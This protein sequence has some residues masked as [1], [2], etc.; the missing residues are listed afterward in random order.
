MVIIQRAVRRMLARREAKQERMSVKIG[1]PFFLSFFLSSS[2]L[3]CNFSSMLP[4][5]RYFDYVIYF[6]IRFL[7]VDELVETEDVY[8]SKLECCIKNFY[9]PLLELSKSK[10]LFV[11]SL[12]LSL[13]LTLPPLRHPIITSEE[14]KTVFSELYVIHLFNQK[15]LADLSITKAT[16]VRRR[17]RG[18]DRGGWAPFNHCLGGNEMERSEIW[19]NCR[20]YC[21]YSSVC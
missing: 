8:V 4:I 19:D 12:S 14:V 17:E 5:F 6:L 16:Q 20:F 10:S 21:T 1:F 11:S 7:S 13:S 9:E 15:F 18:Q 3:F 2:I